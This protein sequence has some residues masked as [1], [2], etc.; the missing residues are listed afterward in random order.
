MLGK[1]LFKT[2]GDVIMENQNPRQTWT[3]AEQISTYRFWGLVI[4]Y[5]YSLFS[6]SFFSRSFS[7]W[8]DNTGIN[9]S[10]IATI[11][12]AFHIFGVIGLFIGWIIVKY[13]SVKNLIVLTSI[14]I[15]SILLVVLAGNAVLKL[16]GASLCGLCYGAIF[17]VVPS[18]I[19][20][21]RAGAGAFAGLYLII[22]LFDRIQNL[23]IGAEIGYMYQYIKMMPAPVYTLLLTIPLILG[24]IFLLPVKSTL[25]EQEPPEK[26]RP[27]LHAQVHNAI[28]IFLLNLIPFYSVY[29]MYR[30]HGDIA[31]F[32][33][34][35]RLLSRKGALWISLLFTIT[36][37][38]IT[39][40][41]YEVI[42]EYGKE[43]N[44]RFTPKWVIMLL[45][46]L[47]YPV[48]FALI[49]SD[50]NK[51]IAQSTPLNHG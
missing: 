41:F 7:L 13:G 30:I 15:I 2:R 44:I 46:I 49:Q 22:L 12:S 29:F 3:W 33:Q 4:F 26:A 23:T 38:I 18:Y 36:L 27:A 51:I 19:A 5:L 17:V 42:E 8:A 28:I 50:L 43:R 34:S 35:R 16:F 39:T 48:A 20:G 24:I 45:T 31:N 6:F 21:G 10:T 32:S 11:F 9:P 37:P 40:T 14:Q 1:E 47:L 25:F